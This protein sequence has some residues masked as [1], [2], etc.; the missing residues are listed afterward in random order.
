MPKFNGKKAIILFGDVLI[1]YTSLFLMFLIRGYSIATAW[2]NHKFPFFWVYILWIL[3]FYSAGMYDW[4]HYPPTRRYYTVQ[5]VGKTMLVNVLVAIMLF[6]LIPSFSIT[7]RTNLFIDAALVSVLIWLWRN[8]FIKRAALRSKIKIL[9]F[10]KTPETENFANYLAEKTMLGYGV[11][12]IADHIK[13]DHSDI[14]SFIKERKIDI[15][16]V[17][18]DISQNIE[19]VRM[20]YE[21][22]P[23]G[24][25]I[26]NFPDF[27]ESITGK[28]PTSLI[29]ETWFLENL[30]ELNN[31]PYEQAKRVLDVAAATFL[32]IPVILLFPIIAFL[33]KIESRGPVFFKQ[34]R[35][36]KNGKVFEFIKFRS[37]IEGADAIG[38]EKGTGGDAR[39]TNVG[40]FLRKTYLDELP[41]IINIF[42]GEMSFVGP[43]PERPEFVEILRDHVQFYETRLLVRPGITGWAQVSMKNDASVEDAPE[44]MQYDLY[45]IKNRS[46]AL[47]MTILLKTFFVMISRGG[48]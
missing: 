21:V 7:P 36:G 1:L 10:G 24:I 9:F 45:Y 42:R 29:N 32:S 35:V 41:Q 33:I 13:F 44:K 11:E 19:L 3:I 12:L 28:I 17:S 39:H 15:V 26:T 16:V 6:Y 20:F 5:L 47:D 8:N 25:T 34:K 2:D 48:R 23:L 4:E 14:K 30:A 22:L 40:K 38:G 46:F 37:M 31:R 18:K 27:Y 43:R